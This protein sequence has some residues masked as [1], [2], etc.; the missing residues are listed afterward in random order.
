MFELDSIGREDL[1]DVTALNLETYLKSTGWDYIGER[2][3]YARVFRMQLDNEHRRTVTVPAFESRDDHSDRIKDALDAI[4]E[5]ESRSRIAVLTD[6]AKADNDVIRVAST[7]GLAHRRLSVGQS[8]DL[9]RSV[10]DL[11]VNTARAAEASEIGDYRA[12]YRGS[13]SSKVSSYID[14]ISYEFKPAEGYQVTLHSPVSVEIGQNA[15]FGDDRFSSPFPRTA[16]IT[17]TRALSA[18]HHA[19]A[20]SLKSL[21]TNSFRQTVESGVSANFCDALSKLAA[22]GQGISIQGRWSLLRPASKHFGQIFVTHQ[23]A[24]VLQSAATLLR[25]SEPSRDEQILCYVTKL[26][27]EPDEFDGRATL[28]ALRDEK[29]VRLRA[30]FAEVMFPVVIQAFL[31]QR[32]L[33]L[34]GDVYPTGN[35]FRLQNPRQLKLLLDPAVEQ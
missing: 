15:D 28:L 23:H 24:E 18:V 9:L 19:L 26:E 21:S 7:N 10:S 12:A 32:E 17:L 29:Y 5:V 1:L 16:T 34:I 13:I 3:Q 31:E 20:E 33:S 25:R 6:L 4:S 11:M 8:A 30:E 22:G 2:G 35:G 27:R 14:G